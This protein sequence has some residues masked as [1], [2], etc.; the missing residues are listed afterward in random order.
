MTQ[1]IHVVTTAEV[2]ERIDAITDARAKQV[3]VVL[4]VQLVGTAAWKQFT[5]A[6]GK[7]AH[8]LPSGETIAS[9]K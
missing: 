8:K 9:A 3:L 2:L 6:L 5:D 1:R 7:P 4:T